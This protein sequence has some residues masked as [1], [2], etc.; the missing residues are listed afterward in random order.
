M[1][2]IIIG[3]GASGL[4]AARE[5]AKAGK[6]VCVLEARNRIGGRIHTINNSSFSYPLEGGAEFI[7]GKLPV[8]LELLKE[9]GIGHLEITG[10]MWQVK[11]GKWTKEEAFIEHTPLLMK[12]LKNLKEDVSIAEFLEKEF[13]EEKYT[14]MKK[15]LLGYVEG[16]Y[17][18]DPERTSAMAFYKEWQSEDEE[19]FRPKS[20][21]TNML[22]YLIQQIEKNGGCVQLSTIV[23][24]VSFSKDK[25]EI[26]DHNHCKYTA[27]RAL[28]T[29]P[30]GVWNA[31]ADCVSF[32]NYTPAI[33][34]IKS[35][36]EE[37][38]F[39]SVIKILL[40]LSDDFWKNEPANHSPVH[41]LKN[42]G[43]IFSDEPIPTWW[44]QLP[45]RIPLLTGWLA[46][47]KAAA[48][49]LASDREI[50]E[51][52]ISSL[53]RILGIEENRLKENL[54]AFH[55]FNWSADPFTLGAY[56]YSAVGSD[57][58]RK[59]LS[60][61]VENTLFFAGDAIYDGPE[62]GTVEAALVSGR[63]VADKIN[64]IG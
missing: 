29:V 49:K 54:Q 53:A 38:G 1:D 10:G 43:F 16:Y 11:N 5:L 28:V 51:K 27:K 46:G 34:Q 39:G 60:E 20:G 25:V 18:G 12:Q 19:Q 17:A 47:P 14:Q 24:E 6:K 40:Q 55:V 33:P 21:Y 61:P 59:I 36:F 30:P 4:M 32:I 45:E 13:A 26:T 56:A 22:Q 50:L 8:T 44:T 48:L 64:A 2:V 63:I 7:H 41:H 62:T 52:A 15:S 9:A 23:K 31:S 58:A 35:A 42:T 57:K 3:A 37:L